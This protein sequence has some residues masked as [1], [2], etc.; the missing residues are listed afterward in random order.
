ML[1]LADRRDLGSRAERREGSSPSFPIFLLFKYIRKFTL[2]IETEALDNHQIKITA[3][4]DNED[5]EN[6]RRRAARI[7]A[8]KSKIPG[9]RPGKAPYEHVV[10]Y[11]GIDMIDQQAIEMIIDDKYPEVLKETEID[12][13]G[14][15]TLEEIVTKEPPKFIFTVPLRPEVSLPDYHTFRKEYNIEPVKDEDVQKVI[16]DIQNRYATAE[17][18]ENPV[19]DGNLV[20]IN[21]SGN[22]LDAEDETDPEIVKDASLQVVIGGNELDPDNWPFEGFTKEL[23]GLSEKDTKKVVHTYEEDS[24]IENLKGKKVE[25]VVAIESIKK[26]V[27][28]EVDDEFVKSLGDYNNVDEFKEEL[29]KQLTEKQ[30]NDYDLQYHNEVLDMIVKDSTIKYPPQ[31]LDEEINEIIKSLEDDLA[32]QNMDIKTYLK[33]LNK[34]LKTFIDEEVRP[35]AI[36][37]LERALVLDKISTEEKIELDKEQLQN[38]VSETLEELEKMQ[39]YSKRPNREKQMLANRVTINTANRMINA[40]IFERLKDI[41]TGKLEEDNKKE[42]ADKESS[43]DNKSSGEESLDVV[44]ENGSPSEESEESKVE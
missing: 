13:Y 7:I 38:D 9:F 24:P 19:E 26:L 25:Y 40:K 18:S 41:T 28:P 21:L 3:E 17:P 8:K 31:L 14:P 5:L 1:E 2:K 35:S 15:G 33:T 10:R 20:Y 30:N 22:I 4:F 43:V 44:E 42:K 37:R 6:Y 36:S 12:S 23:I 11:A 34:D 27:Y 39:D 29:T 32:R 16:K